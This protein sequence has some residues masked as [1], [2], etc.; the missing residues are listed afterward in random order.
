MLDQPGYDDWF[1]LEIGGDMNR[2]NCYGFY[3]LGK[4]IHQ[5]ESLTTDSAELDMAL[6]AV[7]ADALLHRLLRGG[8]VSLKATSQASENVFTGF[9]HLI[10]LVETKEEKGENECSD[11][12]LRRTSI[13]LILRGIRQSIETF[14]TIMSSELALAPTYSVPSRGVFSTDSLL[15]SADDV[16]GDWKDKIPEEARA[17]TRQAGRCLAFNLSTA[18]GFHVARA[19]EAVMRKVMDAFG[20]SL[21]KES[22]RN[23]G[24]YIRALDEHGASKTLVHHL[25]QL[26]ELH[27]NP[28]IHPEVT[29]TPLEAEQL[30]AMC[31]SAMLAMIS[32]IDARN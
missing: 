27:R 6:A 28:L 31:T 5:V 19:T 14:E 10:E 11:L 13:D 32:E 26:K 24:N 7:R 20:C 2:I 29:L 30:W 21:T 22:Q 4:W 3:S 25:T 23:W 18:A 9:K 1:A 15:D 17:D 16:F 8:L 12:R